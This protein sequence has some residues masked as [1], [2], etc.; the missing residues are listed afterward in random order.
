M[1]SR[2]ETIKR[3]I[4]ER[5]IK[6]AGGASV[7]NVSLEGYY[8]EMSTTGIR[9]REVRLVT[10]LSAGRP[11]DAILVEG[12]PRPD[13]GSTH[14]RFRW[15]PCT[16]TYAE[17][18]SP[19]STTQAKVTSEFEID[20]SA[21]DGG[22]ITVPELVKPELEFSSTLQMEETNLH[23]YGD[24]N[25]N[26][27]PIILDQEFPIANPVEGGPTSH[28]ITISPVVEFPIAMTEFTYRKHE[29]ARRRV[30]THGTITVGDISILYTG[31]VNDREIFGGHPKYS[32]M[33]TAIIGASADGGATY[34]M[35]YQF[36]HHPKVYTRHKA[37]GGTEVVGG[38]CKPVGILDDN[39][40][41]RPDL[42]EGD[43]TLADAGGGAVVRLS[44]SSNFDDL[45]LYL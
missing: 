21:G 45:Q 5:I 33:C 40:Y 35:A 3:L 16:R 15:V 8:V 6:A 43:G 36:Q 23:Y 39:G 25:E 9:I 4:Q 29:S 31:T 17:M 11:E 44:P 2:Q 22:L 32:W 14:H 7:G 12:I 28:V 26:L 19:D 20:T 37:G 24:G 42:T 38:W 13:L 27:K 10:G 1:I 41:P 30:G 18:A 34:Q